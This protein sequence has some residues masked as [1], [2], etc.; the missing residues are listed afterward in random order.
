[1]RTGLFTAVFATTLICAPQ[2]SAQQPKA[3]DVAA[4]KPHDPKDTAVRAD[5]LPGGRVI[6]R[7]MFMGFIFEYAY[8]VRHYQ[9]SGEPSWFADRYDI[10]AIAKGE[11]EMTDEQARPYLQALLKDRLNL[12]VHSETKEVPVYDLVVIPGGPKFTASAPGEDVAVKW[13]GP[14]QVSLRKRPVKVIANM[15][16]GN[17][18]IL[19]S[20]TDRTGLEGDFDINLQWTPESARGDASNPGRDGPS[21]FTALQEQLGLKLVAKKAPDQIL[22]IDRVERP[23]D[24]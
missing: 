5:L 24:N 8:G 15:L 12:T 9:T 4:I 7:N 20:V 10:D 6:M 18:D 21:I 2:A 3:F 13:A 22:V 16:S 11:G 23:S 1:M 19:R 14:N 17:P